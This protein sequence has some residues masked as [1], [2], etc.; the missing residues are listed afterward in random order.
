MLYAVIS[1]EELG[2]RRKAELPQA[3]INNP[4]YFSLFQPSVIH[5]T[6]LK[7]VVNALLD[8]KQK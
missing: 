4:L 2:K 8:E 3:M 1:N 5:K 7:S 6:V